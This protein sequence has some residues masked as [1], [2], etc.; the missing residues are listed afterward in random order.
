[1]ELLS[2]E[3]QDKLA[4]IIE[5]PPIDW[6]FE[7]DSP[8]KTIDEVSDRLVSGQH[9]LSFVLEELRVN[10][11]FA[12]PVTSSDRDI[13][14]HQ[15]AAAGHATEGLGVAIR[16]KESDFDNLQHNIDCMLSIL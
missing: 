13:E 16:L 12:I 10:G 2:D 8:K 11:L 6:D 7:Q 14:Y 4:P 9:P 1:M 3:V 5:I 15:E